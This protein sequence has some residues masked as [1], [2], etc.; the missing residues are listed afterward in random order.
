MKRILMRAAKH[1][2][3]AA[4]E[5]ETL[6]HN[7]IGNNTGNLMFGNAAFKLM[8]TPNT[9]IQTDSDKLFRVKPEEHAAW[10]NDSCDVY[11][12]PMANA[13][14]KKFAGHLDILTQIITKLKVPVVM[15]GAG[16]QATLDLDPAFIDDISD[17]VKAFVGSILDRSASVGV[18]GE[19]TKRYLGTLGF[20]DV[21]IIGCPSM[22]VH[23]PG[24]RIEKPERLPS[25]AKIAFSTA[26]NVYDP[27]LLVQVNKRIVEQ[28]SNLTYFAQ[29]LRDLEMMYWG[30]T[31]ILAGREI[32]L[33]KIRSH[34]LIKNG[35]TVVPLEPHG[36]IE[37]LRSYDFALGT[38]IHGNIAALDAGVPGLVIAHDSR[39]LELSQ[40]LDIPYRKITEM[41]TS[42][43]IEELYALADYS[44]FN[45]NHSARFVQLTDFMTRNG[46]E[47]TFDHGDSGAAYEARMIQAH[48]HAPA[49]AWTGG[50]MGDGG[51]RVAMLYEM[52]LNSSKRLDPLQAK[53]AA[54]EKMIKGLTSKL[55]TQEK[56]IT[57]LTK[58]VKKLRPLLHAEKHAD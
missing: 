4:T 12:L 40:Y 21:D 18:R 8:S 55:E 32:D 48:H 50:E 33:P 52:T 16:A 30:D 10:I 5:E 56:T 53:I 29:E 20:S 41:D 7:T 17:N 14:K 2:F 15:F 45:L 23:G 3:W 27:D 37:A 38:R 19:F 34:P 28:S 44:A 54:Q 26:L 51:N 9:S 13:F 22:F 25:N 1:P 47:N 39:T 31:S 36:W 42:F 35:Q 46:L 58:T 43:T 11:V 49:V 6:L 24:F 57:A